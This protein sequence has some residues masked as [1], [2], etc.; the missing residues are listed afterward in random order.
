MHH[1]MLYGVCCRHIQETR[2]TKSQLDGSVLPVPE[3][4]D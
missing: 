4:L 2:N 1:A 3:P